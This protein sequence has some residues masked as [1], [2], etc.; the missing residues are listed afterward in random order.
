MHTDLNHTLSR[1][2][3]CQQV[4]TPHIITCYINFNKIWHVEL[5]N[6]FSIKIHWPKYSYLL[7]NIT[8][9]VVKLYFNNVSALLRT[10]NC[11]V[12]MVILSRY[13]IG[14]LVVLCS[15]FILYS[16][17]WEHGFWLGWWCARWWLQW[18]TSLY[19]IAFGSSSLWTGLPCW[20][21]K[22]AAMHGKRVLL[23]REI[24]NCRVCTPVYH[25]VPCMSWK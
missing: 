17:W 9:S 16:N 19:W 21:E 7:N 23:T 11:F 3:F 12:T 24:W 1:L 18:T 20:R 14:V 22:R 8:S 15:V 13:T 10:V 4:E 6:M 25:D 2:L 5:C